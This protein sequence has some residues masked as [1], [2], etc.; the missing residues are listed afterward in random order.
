[1]PLGFPKIQTE[2]DRESEHGLEEGLTQMVEWYLDD[3][4]LV[5]G[6]IGREYWDYYV[7]GMG[8][9]SEVLQA[10]RQEVGVEETV[11]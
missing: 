1:M 11:T 3:H 2:L 5:E 7:P 4:E 10:A 6:A 9:V 8:N